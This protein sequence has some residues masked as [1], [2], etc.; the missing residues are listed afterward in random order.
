MTIEENIKQIVQARAG[1]RVK[2]LPAVQE[3]FGLSK[4]VDIVS[5]GDHVCIDSNKL[6]VLVEL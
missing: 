3:K 5:F 2:V 6:S 4:Y 1:S